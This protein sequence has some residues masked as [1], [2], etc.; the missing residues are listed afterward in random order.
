MTTWQIYMEAKDAA[1]HTV[2]GAVRVAHAVHSPQ[3][4]NKRD[5]LVYL[6]PSYHTNHQAYPVLYMHDGQNLFDQATS[7]SGEW[8][9]DETM[10]T[11]AAEQREAIVVG[12]PNMGE[13]RIAE[14]SPFETRW[15]KG[16]GDA[17]LAFLV[18]TLKPLVDQSFRT[19]PDRAHTGIAGSSMGGLI[20]MYGYF[21]HP[22]VFGLAGVM[23][24]A[25]WIAGGKL[26]QFVMQHPHMPGKLYL[27][28][29]EQELAT[30]RK[31]AS[32]QY[33]NS[34][35]RLY[36]DLVEKGYRPEDE[37]HYTQDPDGTHN[38]AAW[39]RRLPEMLRFLLSPYGERLGSR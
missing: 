35:Q 10:E 34:V 25:F 28:I 15:G 7:Y 18:D 32:Q 38:E 16:K 27:D 22:G 5:I 31:G 1:R 21:R 11:L 39:A 33:A 2:V 36:L 13:H 17:Y 9:V 14:Y 30:R 3:L 29:G 8:R 12:I 6:P 24:P 20:S 23:S 37:I 19:L 4:N 26:E